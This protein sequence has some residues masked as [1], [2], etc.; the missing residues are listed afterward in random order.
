MDTIN[1]SVNTSK[2]IQINPREAI[3]TIALRIFTITLSEKMIK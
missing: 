1:I 2:T 3:A